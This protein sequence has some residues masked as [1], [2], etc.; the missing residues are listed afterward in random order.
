MAVD[1][2]VIVVD[3]LFF[4]FC[5]KS[6]TS[7]WDTLPRM[8]LEQATVHRLHKSRRLLLLLL[9][10]RC[11]SLFLLLL[12][13]E[14]PIELVERLLFVGLERFLLLDFGAGFVADDLFLVAGVFNVDDFELTAIDDEVVKLL[15]DTL[16]LLS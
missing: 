13:M 2:V 14:L 16:P 10:P 11:V 15:L 6:R 12:L 9:L 3:E 7:P 8:D 5:E 4:Q 1:E